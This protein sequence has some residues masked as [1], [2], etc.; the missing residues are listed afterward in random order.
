MKPKYKA[1][2][3]NRIRPHAWYASRLGLTRQMA[4]TALITGVF[5]QDGAYLSQLLRELDKLHPDEVCNLAGSSS[6]AQFFQA[7]TSEMFGNAVA[8]PQDESSPFRTRSPYA[9]AKLF[10]HC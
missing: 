4:K 8:S 7:S 5:G 3:A 6:V 10:A 2:N 9:A 1:N